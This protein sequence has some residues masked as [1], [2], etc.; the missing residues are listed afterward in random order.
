MN[1]LLEASRMTARVATIDA[2]LVDDL[3]ELCEEQQIARD[4]YAAFYSRWGV[5]VLYRLYEEEDRHVAAIK[6]LTDRNGVS[7]QIHS[8]RSGV[9]AEPA[10]QA[11][12][13]ELAACGGRSL[14]DAYT[15]S[16]AIERAEIA[17]L[18]GLANVTTQPEVAVPL[19]DLRKDDC[20]HLAI[21]TF[22]SGK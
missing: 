19:R 8:S 4:L 14:V 7:N 5:Q 12:Y 9:F 17:L 13:D 11:R 16:M 6:T 21:L 22:L 1:G 15:I 3:T 2:Q 18:S 10:R 20:N